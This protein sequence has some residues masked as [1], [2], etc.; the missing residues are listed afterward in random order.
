MTRTCIAS[1]LQNSNELHIDRQ[2]SSLQW[3]WKLKNVKIS[4]VNTNCA[5]A[6]QTVFFIFVGYMFK[7]VQNV[8]CYEL[9]RGQIMST[10]HLHH[11]NCNILWQNICLAQCYNLKQ[12][13]NLLELQGQ[14]SLLEIN[15]STSCVILWRLPFILIQFEYCMVSR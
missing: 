15:L 14:L 3:L 5:A 12:I 6:S 10:K 9:P 8:Q 11:C 1:T 13:F 4:N 7:H 2:P